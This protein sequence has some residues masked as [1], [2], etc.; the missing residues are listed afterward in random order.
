MYTFQI[1]ITLT[2]DEIN[3]AR[4]KKPFVSKVNSLKKQKKKKKQTL[5]SPRSYFINN[6]LFPTKTK[7]KYMKL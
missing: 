6:M 4:K 5:S 1:I 2:C 3:F 7:K